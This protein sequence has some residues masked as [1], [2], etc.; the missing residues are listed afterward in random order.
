MTRTRPA[1]GRRT[2]A[3]ADATDRRR[4]VT[5]AGL[6]LSWAACGASRVP[7]PE[8]ELLDEPGVS[9]CS[10]LS[11]EERVSCP[12]EA[13]G[14]VERIDDVP[15]GVAITYEAGS[16]SAEKMRRTIGC[17]SAL[18]R[19]H[20]DRPPFC[21]FFDARTEKVVL[22]RGRRVIVRLTMALGESPGVL[23][24]RVRTALEPPR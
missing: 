9:D 12:L 18:A 20:T 6:A 24:A 15:G 17:Q 1:G 10:G 11:A 8:A 13:Y 7:R 14:V 16:V 19:V 4:L 23:R 21:P 22:E 5:W 3:R 2:R